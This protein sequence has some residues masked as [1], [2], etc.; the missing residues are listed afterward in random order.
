MARRAVAK[1][2]D[3]LTRPIPLFRRLLLELQSNCNRSCFF[4]NR[5]WDDSGKRV[6]ADGG[7]VMRSMP[8]EHASRIMREAAA[9]GFRGKIAFHHM[10]EPFLDP[11]IIEMAREAKRLGL[12]PY[13]HTN[14]DVLR[15]DD[16][17]CRAA[18]G[19]FDYIVV[20]LY[21]YETH[22][23]RAAEIAFWRDRLKG[24]DVRF[25]LGERVF[26][27]GLTP[28]DAR[29]FREKEPFPGG[30]CHMPLERLIVHYDGN[31][32]LCCEDMKDDFDLGNAF[33][34]SVEELWYSERHVGIIRDLEQG[35]REKF[36]TC[37]ACPIPPPVQ[38]GPADRLLG[39]VKRAGEKLAAWMGQP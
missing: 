10:S 1:G 13:E 25:S 23:E 15:K 21:D 37:A 7:H 18:V 26:P 16:E 28:M 3:M 29:M 11:R 36:K 6:D 31:V 8:A 33:Q 2:G 12:H 9:L 32:A 34:S 35:R 39:R 38:I 30:V 20:G 22:A 19:V 5:P 27:R 14:G 24:C 4:C 17:L